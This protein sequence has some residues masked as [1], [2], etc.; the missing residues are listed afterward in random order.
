ME[1]I[2]FHSYVEQASQ[3]A[4]KGD[5]IFASFFRAEMLRRVLQ[6][7]KVQE[8][9]VLQGFSIASFEYFGGSIVK[10]AASYE[11]APYRRE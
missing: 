11:I 8:A 7:E 5:F 3:I 1:W 2:P 9:V 6:L 10:L 4:G